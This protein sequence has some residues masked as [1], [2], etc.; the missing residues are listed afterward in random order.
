MP[1]KN[2]LHPWPAPEKVWERIQVDF[3]GLMEGSTYMV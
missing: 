3:T 1:T 2:I